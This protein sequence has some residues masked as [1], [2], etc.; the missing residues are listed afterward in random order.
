MLSSGGRGHRHTFCLIF[1]KPIDL[2]HGTVESH[3]IEFLMIG[4]I[5]EKVLAHDGQTD[6]AEITT[7]SDPRKSADIDAGQTGATVSSEF[8]ST[9][10]S[11]AR[12]CH[13]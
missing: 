12:K 8:S 6:E 4:N 5:Q 3:D 10:F 2:G 13:D 9:W 7:G 1:Y 11:I